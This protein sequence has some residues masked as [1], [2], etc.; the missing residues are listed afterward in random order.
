VYADPRVAVIRA[1]AGGYSSGHVPGA[2]PLSA[3]DASGGAVLKAT[4]VDGLGEA[5]ALVPTGET[6]DQVIQNAGVGPNTTIVISGPGEGGG[7]YYATRLYWTL[8][9]WGFPRERLKLIQG[10]T[11]AYADEFGLVFEDVQTPETGYTVEGFEEPNYGVRK[12]LNEMLQLVDDGS[13]KVI[14]QRTGGSFDAKIAG[15]HVES[16]A[17]YVEGDSFKKP[18]NWKSADA[19]KE[20][21]F[22]YDGVEDGDE[23]VTMCHSGFKG[24]LAF[25]ALDGIVGYDNAAL[26]DGSWKFMW[27]QYN[28]EQDPTPND[29]WR[30]DMHDRTEGEITATGQVSIDPDLNE[31]LTELAT[32][33]ANQVKKDAIEYIVGDTSGDFGCGS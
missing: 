8:R 11:K 2:V 28:G 1:D 10:G 18:A 21:V 20:H 24:T 33:D 16:A 17:N 14:D 15:S 22:G 7:M 29:A 25:F 12:G 6:V 4:R 3:G 5:K 9:F 23:I 32:L 26:F 30:A 27:K 31:Q 19:I 13:A